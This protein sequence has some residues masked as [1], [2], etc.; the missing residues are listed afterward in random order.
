L[1]AALVD[2]HV[3]IAL[4]MGPYSYEGDLGRL[5]TAPET[6]LAPLR[7]RVIRIDAATEQEAFEALQVPCEALVFDPGSAEFFSERLADAVKRRGI[8]VIVVRDQQEHQVSSV[9]MTRLVTPAAA[10]SV[11][12]GGSAAYECAVEAAAWFAWE[13]RRE[14]HEGDVVPSRRI[15]EPD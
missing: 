6:L 1:T 3:T 2:D 8:P 11:A 13:A 5:G 10:A 7:A 15:A 9:G 12:G 14:T 4:I